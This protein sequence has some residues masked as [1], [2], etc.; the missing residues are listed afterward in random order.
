VT[1]R[2]FLSHSTPARD[3]ERLPEIKAAI[4][5]ASEGRV[6]VLYDQEQI[7][8]GNEWRRRIG[9]LLHACD[10]AAILL[11]D[12][13]L[14]SDWVRAE[15]VFLSLRATYDEDFRVVPVSV[16]PVDTLGP[17][18]ADA[19]WEPV[20]LLDRQFALAGTPAEIAEEVWRA[21][22][23]KGPLP[24]GSSLMDRL[25]D[26]IEQLL[27]EAPRSA[28][29]DL[30]D[31]LGADVP[32]DAADDHVRSALVIARRLV[33]DPCL[34]P[35]VELLQGLGSRFMREYAAD[36]LE[37]L[38]PLPIDP[39]AAAWLRRPR[40]GGGPGHTWLQTDKPQQ[41]VALDVQRAYLTYGS[42]PL[43]AIV[44]ESGT[45]AETRAALRHESVQALWPELAGHLDDDEVD[46]LLRGM[47]LYVCSPPLDGEVVGEL[48]DD[49]P[50]LGFVFHHA[51]DDPTQPPKGVNRVAPALKRTQESEL[52]RQ[53]LLAMAAV[54]ANADSRRPGGT[55]RS[56]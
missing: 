34:A 26:Q 49:Y 14:A 24:R 51:E 25:A 22:T 8:G 38:Q 29:R 23:A 17:R 1:Y 41:T 37:Y 5:A 18:L 31:E 52:R 10:G 33:R 48:S 46:D 35:V 39:A 47:K 9:Y 11:D 55:R 19:G 54:R 36:V 50:F 44:P 13:A 6:R 4:E 45:A 43:I 2:L 20:A 32:Y 53:W 21:L 27:R 56:A 3:R 30:A 28:L 12:A 40:P 7:A 42:P 15:A 16:L